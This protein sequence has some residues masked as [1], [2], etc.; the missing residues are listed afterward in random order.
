MRTT[1][2]IDDDVLEAAL[3]LA[4]VDGMNLGKALS[5]L[6]LRGLVRRDRPQ[7]DPDFPLFEV[8][9]GSPPITLEL[10]RRAWN[11]D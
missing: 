6:A 11:G 5:E 1:L 3:S 9:P 2:E 8:G 4:A 10:V 7:L